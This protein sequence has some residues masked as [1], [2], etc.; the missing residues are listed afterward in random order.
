MTVTAPNHERVTFPEW[1]ARV[2]A[3][4]FTGAV[5]VHFGQGVANE[6]QVLA[7]EARIAFD[8]PPKMR[9]T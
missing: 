1:L 6:A 4:R 8:K 5:V 9:H 3:D 7:A 2:Y